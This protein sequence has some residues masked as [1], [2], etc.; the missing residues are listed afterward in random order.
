MPE[1]EA[2]VDNA[3][4]GRS[5]RPRV[6]FAAATGAIALAAV[7]APRTPVPQTVHSGPGRV[8]AMAQDGQTLAWLDADGSGCNTV[9]VLGSRGAA[10]TA[11]QPAAGSMTCHWDVGDGTPRL[12]LAAGASAV[13]W[14]LHEG[15]GAPLDYVMTAAL[16]GPEVRVDRLA[17]ASDGTGLWLGGV[18]GAGA[19]LAYSVTDVEYANKLGCLSGDS[20]KRVVAGGGVYVVAGGAAKLLPGSRPA[21]A[22][23]TANGRI[24]YVQTAAA[25]AGPPVA[26]ASLPVRVVSADDGALLCFVRPRGVPLAIALG[27]DV[28][29]LLTRSGKSD[30]ISWY[31]ATRGTELGGVAA[32]ASAASVIAASDRIVVYRVGR[33]LRG[34]SLR[35]GHTRTLVRAASTPLSFSLA[36]S[37]LAWAESR[38]GTSRI[39]MLD[40]G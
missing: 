17:H 30:R 14:T 5:Y 13:L 4:T 15:G 40:V 16:D 6:R 28:L 24:A 2:D 12:A 18:A 29:A 38:G 3:L 37:R 39:R 19:T 31:D 10:E 20:C 1:D 7:A 9:H 23:A 35:T 33:T 8:A 21:L 25:P 22:L 27:P 32:P 11:P 26:N 34:V 36:G